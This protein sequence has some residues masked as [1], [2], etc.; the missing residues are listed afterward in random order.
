MDQYHPMRYLTLQRITIASISLLTLLL[1]YTLSTPLTV[2]LTTNCL[3]PNPTSYAIMIDAGST[4]SRLHLYHF[5]QCQ[6]SLPQLIKEDFYSLQPGLSAFAHS[7]LEAAQSLAPMLNSA[8][9]SIPKNQRACT[10]VQVKATAGLR[11]LGEKQSAEILH[12]VEIMLRKEYQFAVGVNAVE[13]MKGRD[14]G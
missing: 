3:P 10:N 5:R 7:P 14:E 9:D 11:L 1:Y 6:N 2:P 12:Q 8:T 13:I 4:G